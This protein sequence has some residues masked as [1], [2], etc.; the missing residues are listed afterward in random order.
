MHILIIVLFLF[1]SFFV[2][3]WAFVEYFFSSLRPY[4][5]LPLYLILSVLLS[6]LIIWVLSFIFGYSVSLI[7][8]C[9]L[10]FGIFAIFVYLKKKTGFNFDKQQV[11]V[12]TFFYL[13]FFIA[14]YPGIFAFHNGYLTLSSV[15]W[16]D[17]AMH[18]G[19]IES[20]SQGNFPPQ[21]PYFA[22][23][24]LSYY[25]LADFHAS[26]LVKLLG[27]SFA[28]SI[29]YINPMFA[30]IFSMSIWAVIYKHSKNKLASAIGALL[31]TLI[32]NFMFIEFM[33]DWSINR[34]LAH[35]I[36]LLKAKAYTMQYQGL[37]EM[38]PMADY[39]LQNRPMM[40]ALP[41]LSVI[42]LLVSD[43]DSKKWQKRV[44]LAAFINILLFKFQAFGFLAG[45]LAITLSLL[46]KMAPPA[47]KDGTLINESGFLIKILSIYICGLFLFTLVSPF[48]GNLVVLAFDN[49]SFGP[50]VK[51]KN[52][53]WFLLFSFVN[54]SPLFFLG[55]AAAFGTTKTKIESKAKNLFLFYLI[56]LYLIPHLMNFTVYKADMFK[57]FYFMQIAVVILA[58]LGL[59]KLWRKKLGKIIAVCLIVLST[60]TSCLTL[61]SS[62]L[63]K[64]A[65]Y[66]KAE[67]KAGVWIRQN[68]PAQSVFIAAPSVHS[69]ITQIGGRLRILSYLTWPYTHGYYL[70]EDNVFWRREKINSY[71]QNPQS[72]EAKDILSVLN[73]DYVYVG[74]LEQSE[75]PSIFSQLISDSSYKLVFADG[76]IYIFTF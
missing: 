42:L 3:G 36:S 19:I 65:A 63:N 23:K 12:G 74:K 47:L 30:A 15:N 53:F 67:Y 13:L 51:N 37:Q 71:L 56:I 64:N 5:K 49:F 21:A 66:T 70:G 6:T 14:L 33:G 11:F 17:T 52:I 27:R 46:L 26:M 8:I 2:P 69:P 62:F 48:S 75:Y 72:Q 60:L 25:Y 22:G 24:P 54:F 35:A 7:I 32:G 50:W 40:L 41:A 34:G 4:E 43:F 45:L 44:L 38:V 10:L 31:S 76:G 57:F 68:T 18:L 1:F 59:S 61:V 39:F 28:R 9:Y 73:V 16:Q 58:S 20:L 55:L 29:V